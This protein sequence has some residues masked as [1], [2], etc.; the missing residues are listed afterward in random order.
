MWFSL[1]SLVLILCIAFFQ[2]LQGLFSAVIMCMLTIV[3]AAL[4]FGVY[5]NLYYGPLFAQMPDQGEAVALVGVFILTLIV[6]RTLFDNLIKGNMQF[7]VWV[8]RIGGGALGLVS[9][10]IVV[11]MLQLGFELL[12]FDGTF[13]G[14]NRFV[15]ISKDRR[16][17]LTEKELQKKGPDDIVWRRDNLML[18][19]DE[20]TVRLIAL[21]SDGALGGE[22]RFRD[23]HPDFAAEVQDSRS[24]VQRESRHVAG[25]VDAIKVDAKGYWVMPPGRLMRPA[26]ITDKAGNDSFTE[27]PVDVKNGWELRVYHV[28]L[29]EPAQDSDSRLRFKPNQVRIVGYD[30][31]GGTPSA[32]ILKGI[33]READ[34]SRFMTLFRDPMF[35]K[36]EWSNVNRPGKKRTPLDFVFEVPKTFQASFI[37]FKR[38]ARADV[39]MVRARPEQELAEPVAAKPTKPTAPKS[40][41]ITAPPG[42]PSPSGANTQPPLGEAPDRISGVWL[43]KAPV[44]AE[45]MPLKLTGQ[46]A[47]LEIEN[48][49]V[50]G[51]RCALEV[52]PE[53]LPQTDA[54]RLS[55]DIPDGRRLLFVPLQELDPQSFLGKARGFAQ[56]ALPTVTLKLE[57]GQE[58]KPVGKY[59]FAKIGPQWWFELIYLD[60]TA[61][62]AD[63]EIPIFDKIHHADL[64][65]PT[66]VYVYL[67]LVPSG[68]K[69]TA[70]NRAKAEPIDLK[71]FNLV[72]PK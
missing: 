38:T 56:R 22:T 68:G 29:E 53:N 52:K 33:D 66:S 3:S 7:P 58:I 70:L 44:Y 69:A 20:F 12:P 43:S 46:A 60:E 67:F 13:L 27:T 6:L 21:L 72:A 61:R 28:F 4:A 37:E 71:S 35:G 62:D 23:V 9:A 2:A 10:I 36:A 51:G 17:E 41:E 11:G 1:F 64:T 45:R 55:F 26:M 40:P 18:S 39:S 34:P 31:P 5:E 32:Y 63:R 25:A 42:L 16:A 14:F 49:K 30:R 47:G 19:P 50:M 8:D 48:G 54:D 15:P 57:N 59:A 24:G 65:E